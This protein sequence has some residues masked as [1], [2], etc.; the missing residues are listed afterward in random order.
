M[1]KIITISR[2]FGSGGRE[3]GRRI[4]NELGF[5]YYDKEIVKEI[6]KRTPFSEDYVKNV[7]DNN[8][9]PLFPIHTGQSF[10][11]MSNAIFEQNMQIYDEQTK[12]IRE[13]ANKSSCVI[14]GRCA[15]YILEDMNPYRI[16]VYATM[17]AKIARCRS[18]EEEGHEFLTDKKFAKKIKKIDKGRAKYYNFFT[19]QVWGDRDNYDLM[20]NTTSRDI[21]HL[22]ET[23]A[24]GIKKI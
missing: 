2:E 13:L 9:V 23:I 12:L 16:F 22:A 1:N 17:D 20:V 15:D 14:V 3:L 19:S 5:A 4:A 10:S 8:P 11:P 18:R 24:E 6:S 21:K 7:M